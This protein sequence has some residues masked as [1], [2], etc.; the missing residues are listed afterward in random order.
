MRETYREGAYRIY[1]LLSLFQFAV[2][3]MRIF[4]RGTNGV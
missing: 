1:I 3:L 2:K 4:V